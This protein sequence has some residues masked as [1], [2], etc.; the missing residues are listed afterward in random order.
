MRKILNFTSLYL[1][2]FRNIPKD[3]IMQ[4]CNFSMFFFKFKNQRLQNSQRITRWSKL[5]AE[6]EIS[7]NISSGGKSE[8]MYFDNF[9]QLFR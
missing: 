1:Q 6:F 7:R 4:I 9:G 3:S 5:S 8:H 2:I